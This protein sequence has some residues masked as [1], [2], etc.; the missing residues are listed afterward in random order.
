M[1]EVPPIS[2]QNIEFRALS[3]EDGKT[4]ILNIMLRSRTGD[5]IMEAVLLSR[6]MYFF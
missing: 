2:Q 1:G 6:S 4:E 5:P 3:K